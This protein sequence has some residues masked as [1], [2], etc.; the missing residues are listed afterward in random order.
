L[1]ALP[2]SQQPIQEEFELPPKLSR[3]SSDGEA[4]TAALLSST[5]SHSRTFPD[6]VQEILALLRGTHQVGNTG[7]HAVPGEQAQPQLWILGSKAGE[8]ARLA[9]TLGLPFGASYHSTPTTAI[10]AIAAY[11]TAFVPSEYLSRPHVIVS[12]E[13]VVGVTDARARRDAAGYRPWLRSI[14]LGQGA[15][16]FP[17]SRE[18]SKGEWTPTDEALVR[19]RI[20][21]LIV[22]SPKTVI[23]RLEHLHAATSADELLVS[24]ITHSYEARLRSYRLLAAAWSK[25]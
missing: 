24:T 10:G 15:I 4:I 19:D 9:G 20:A 1:P 13:V 2:E 18:V 12:A 25:R 11:R 7:V 21:S 8:S 5:S 22:G 14:L 23:E 16:P 6:Q 17:S 3:S